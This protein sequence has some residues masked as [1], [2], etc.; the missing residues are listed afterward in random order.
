MYRYTEIRERFRKDI[1]NSKPII[2]EV[3]RAKKNTRQASLN[4]IFNLLAAYQLLI[5]ENV[6]TGEREE[7]LRF[8]EEKGVVVLKIANEDIIHKSD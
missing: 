7:A 5:C 4:E 2:Q 8:Q 3:I 1:L 6:L